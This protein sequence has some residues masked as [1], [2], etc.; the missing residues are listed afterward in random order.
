MVSAEAR[1]SCQPRLVTLSPVRENRGRPDCCIPPPCLCCF[2][3]FNPPVSFPFFLSLSLSPCGSPLGGAAHV[4]CDVFVFVLFFLALA[5]V[6][7]RTV[8]V[9]VVLLDSS[10]LV[11]AFDRRF[12]EKRNKTFTLA[13]VVFFS[14]VFFLSFRDVV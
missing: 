3:C 14:F 11:L 8:A 7:M 9:V 6:E 2:T 10:T 13:F 5:D 12:V 1:H 4:V